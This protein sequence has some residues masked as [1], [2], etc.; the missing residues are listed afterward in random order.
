M[1][2]SNIYLSLLPSETMN[3]W[4]IIDGVI[5]IIYCIGYWRFSLCLLVGIALAFAA[6]GGIAAEPLRWFI[7]GVIVISS[8]VIGWRWQSRY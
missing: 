6:A 7:A 2:E 3:L 1:S 5:E 4:N 8:I